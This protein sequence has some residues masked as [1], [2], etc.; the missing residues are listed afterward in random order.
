MKA[1][2]I[3]FLGIGLFLSGAYI[4]ISVWKIKTFGGSATGIVTSRLVVKSSDG[5]LYF[6]V[7]KYVVKGQ[8]KERKVNFN[9]NRIEDI[10]I[11]STIQV[12]YPLDNPNTIYIE[13]QNYIGYGLFFMLIGAFV[14]LLGLDLRTKP[15]I[16]DYFET[17]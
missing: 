17:D 8:E 1:F 9:C 7:V 14:G 12:F 10:Q 6:G 11:G 5:D 4:I 16:W 13:K 15:E 2:V 3:I